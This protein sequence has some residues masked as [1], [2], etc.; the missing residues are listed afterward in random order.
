MVAMT[1]IGAR[2]FGRIWRNRFLAGVEPR[3][4]EAVLNSR[5]FD[6]AYADP[7]EERQHQH[8]LPDG[9]GGLEHLEHHDGAEQH[10]QGEEDVGDTAQHRVD[11]TAEEAGDGTDQGTD[12]HDQ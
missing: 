12:N 11:P 9:L 7:A 1:M 2:E 6:T 5:F 10:R 4:V 3:A 8:D